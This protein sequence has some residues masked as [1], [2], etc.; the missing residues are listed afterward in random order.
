MGL[1]LSVFLDVFDRGNMALQSLDQE[2]PLRFHA[3][4]VTPGGIALVVG[5][6]VAAL[7]ISGCLTL[8]CVLR[9]KYIW[10]SRAKVV[11]YH[12]PVDPSDGEE[13][14]P[15]W[16]HVDPNQTDEEEFD[17]ERLDRQIEAFRNSMGNENLRGDDVMYV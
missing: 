13:L 4:T 10:G 17:D 16:Q 8:F 3:E 15:Q 14:K 6:L 1:R 5:V 2:F 7:V 12:E 9:V 11:P